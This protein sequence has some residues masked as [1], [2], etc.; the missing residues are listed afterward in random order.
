MIDTIVL[1]LPSHLFYIHRPE[2]FAPHAGMLRSM[3]FSGSMIKAVYNPTKADKETG[4]KPRLTLIRRPA[5]K[6][7]VSMS[8]RIEFSAPKLIFGNNFEEL[9]GKDHFQPVIN[10]LHTALRDMGIAISKE[11]LKTASVSAIHYSKNILLEAHTP[12]FVLIQALEKLDVPQKLDLTQT[13]F[14]NAGQMVKYHA[15]TYEIALYDKVKDLEQ[16]KKYG[17]G[18]GAETDY[19]TQTDI[20]KNASNRPEVL[21]FEVRLKS[22]KLKA[23]LK[24]LQQHHSLTFESLFNSTLSRCILL[25]YWDQITGGF[26]AMTIDT[27]DVSSLI[28][29]IRISFPRKRPGKI[30][31]MIGIITASQ[32]LGW[33][34]AALALGLSRPNLYRMKKDIQ[35]LALQAKEPRFS[36]LYQIKSQIIEFVPL[37]AAD[38]VQKDILKTNC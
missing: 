20:F 18:R 36:V 24:T 32:Q 34:G 38:I 11:H 17:A 7:I 14:R 12:C 19:E 16:A 30:A 33:R 25:H 1:T 2:K 35:V 21:R 6:G 5:P 13:D 15:S 31:E 22:K 10:A 29:S 4:Y 28:Q 9:R 37:V 27:K 8:L 3:A 26:S 23:L